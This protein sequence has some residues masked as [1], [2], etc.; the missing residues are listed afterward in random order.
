MA[1]EQKSGLASILSVPTLLLITALAGGI[2]WLP[3][4]LIPARPEETKH[5]LPGEIGTQDVEARLWQDPFEA[6]EIAGIPGKPNTGAAIE[7]SRASHDIT[8]L[9]TQ[10][11]ERFT[12][13]N[14]KAADVDGRIPLNQEIKVILAMVSGGRYAEDVESRIRSR[15]A[16]MAAMGTCGYRSENEERIG[17]IALPWPSQIVPNT[18]A[19]DRSEGGT[20]A[21]PYEWFVRRIHHPERKLDAKSTPP[22]NHVL[23]LWLRDNMF[24]DDPAYRLNTLIGSIHA[25]STGA[26][27]KLSI[28]GPQTST[29]LRGFFPLGDWDRAQQAQS[30]EELQKR[31]GTVENSLDGAA[32]F[33]WGA[34]TMDGL[35]VPGG[36]NAACRSQIQAHLKTVFGIDFYNVTC[37]D[38]ALA[39]ALLDE[40]ARR[41]VD[42]SEGSNHIALISE[43]DTFYGRTIPLTLAYK[44]EQNY[45]NTDPTLLQSLRFNP[46]PH[47]GH[48]LH[49]FSYLQGID[50]KLPVR[51]AAPSDEAK[52]GTDSGKD[53]N[54]RPQPEANRAEGPS[55]LDYIPRL[56]DHIAEENRRLFRSAAG[57]IRAI[58]IMGSDVYDKLLVL[59]A[60]RPRF[61]DAVFFTTN[62]D[63]RLWHPSQLKWT[64]NIIVASSFGLE[65]RKKLQRDIPPFRDSY[66]TGQYLAGL[67]VLGAVPPKTLGGISPRIF[68]IGRN[69]A[70]DLTSPRAANSEQCQK[71][72]FFSTLREEWIAAHGTHRDPIYPP[73][74]TQFSSH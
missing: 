41:N 61:P 50:G 35:L 70:V 74:R 4:A 67:G 20:L 3:T 68:E 46:G 33:S 63:A 43:W 30:G 73:T 10:I 51:S 28:L 6:L 2:L 12:R 52:T 15:V 19:Q 5:N 27:V 25:K 36:E 42:P 44:L 16:L 18:S 65:L 37:T 49:Q 39:S 72:N 31:L 45:G 38:N 11:D 32:M 21:L 47:A 48:Q 7:S 8:Q 23:V 26:Q 66:Q 58:G 55:Q 59:Q 60:L 57:E 64:R 56:A 54:K 69:G 17:Y 1:E 24:A 29:T 9:S 34:T 14:P 71:R 22:S 40:L 13:W 62:L 53:E